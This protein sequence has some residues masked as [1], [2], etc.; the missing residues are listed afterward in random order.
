MN[1]LASQAYR[2]RVTAIVWR[3]LSVLRPYGKGRL[4]ESTYL[5]YTPD[6]EQAYILRYAIDL[7]VHES[8]MR[9]AVRV[10]HSCA[11]IC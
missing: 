8:C 6:I 4:R 11:F 3:F 2:W 9:V 5:F 1:N 10:L 7:H